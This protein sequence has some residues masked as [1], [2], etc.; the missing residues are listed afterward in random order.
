MTHTIQTAA[1]LIAE[2]DPSLAC[3]FIANPF[4]RHNLVSAFH[5]GLS[6]SKFAPMADRIAVALRSAIDAEIQPATERGLA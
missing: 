5:A 2:I 6:K 1:A 4:Q 3:A